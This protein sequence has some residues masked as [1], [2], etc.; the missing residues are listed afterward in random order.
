MLIR[1]D[2]V[3]ALV[4]LA[5]MGGVYWLSSKPGREL[6]S[7]GWSAFLLDLGHIPLFA[8]LALVT[9][10]A[11]VGPPR[12]LRMLIAGVLCLVFAAT[13]EWHQRYVPG[14]VAS[15]ADVRS[16]A[17]GIALGLALAEILARLAGLRRRLGG[18]RRGDAGR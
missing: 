15:L 14:R 17:I 7:W 1:L 18:S 13:D 12:P 11:L 6:A 16:D 2:P 10:W 4:A 9:L 8:G 3:R 5:Y